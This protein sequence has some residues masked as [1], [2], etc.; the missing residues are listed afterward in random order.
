MFS[1]INKCIIHNDIHSV[2]PSRV[3]LPNSRIETITINHISDA[4]EVAACRRRTVGPTT[5]VLCPYSNVMAVVGSL[6]LLFFHFGHHM[7]RKTTTVGPGAVYTL[8]RRRVRS[9]ASV[10]G[11]LLT[12]G[13]EFL[14]VLNRSLVLMNAGN[15][16]PLLIETAA[17]PL[18]IT[19][20][21]FLLRFVL[22]FIP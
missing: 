9:S 10:V 2:H 22:N 4:G 7:R 1:Y 8:P 21:F 15:I 5:S 19:I 13:S 18:Q 17:P 11:N 14:S 16:Q 3:S 12:S 20:V 6:S